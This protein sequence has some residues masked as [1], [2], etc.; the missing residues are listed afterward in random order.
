MSTSETAVRAELPVAAPVPAPEPEPAVPTDDGAAAYQQHR[1]QLAQNTAANELLGRVNQR[2]AAEAE[3]EITDEAV[4]R[5]QIPRTRTPAG[6]SRP[7]M[8]GRVAKDMALG[9]IEAPRAIVTGFRGA[10]QSVLDLEQE[11]ATFLETK[12]P[13][14]GIRVTNKDGE[15]EISYDE[16]KDTE[17]SGLEL[18]GINNPKSNTG[19]MLKSITQF[20]VGMAGASKIK[21]LQSLSSMGTA[22]A[23]TAA[24][25]KGA[26]ADFTVFGPDESRLSNL[27][28]Q[29]PALQNPV[30]EFLQTDP[31][32]NAAVSRFKNSLE[33]IPL[34]VLTDGFVAGIRALRNMRHARS[35][36]GFG[37]VSDVIEA[38]R[39]LPEDAFRGLGDDSV[40]PKGSLIR[41]RKTDVET[42]R[43]RQTG[44]KADETFINF[45]RI[46]SPDDVKRAMQEMADAGNPAADAAR[47]GR[48]TFAAV[49]LDA[50]HM[51]GWQALVNR[52]PGQPLGDAESLAARQLWVATT[53]KVT[54][55]AKTAAESPSEAN[56]FAF[57]KMLEVHDLVQSE[58]L[59]ARA[60]AA[61]SLASWRI[62]AGGPAERMRDVA[63][64]LEASGGKEVAQ[65]L[66]DRIGRLGQAGFY[67]EMGAVIQKTAYAKTRDAVIEG[68]VMGLLSGPKTHLVNM[69]SNTSVIGMNI[70][71]RGTA[72]QIA[73][74][75]GDEQ[76]VAL[77]EGTAQMFGII[78]GYKDAFR[79]AWKALKTGE[80]GFGLNK[81]ELPR[82]GS[83]SSQAF[84][85][86]NT[87]VGRAVDG[88]GNVVRTPGRMLG[89][90]DE[91]FKTIGYRME[92]NAQALRMAR[93]E[94]LAGKIAPDQFKARI[95]EIKA[96]PPENIRMAAVDQAMYQTFTNAT[97]P[98]A[99]NLSKIA[100]R[101]PLTRVLMPFIR[102]PA[103]IMKFTFERTPLAPLMS[104]VRADVAAG[105]AR[106]DLALAR[107]ATGTAIMLATTDHAMNGTIS[108]AG[109]SD[110]AE[111]A[112]LVRSG[113]QPYSVKAGER[114]YAYNRLDPMGALF[115]LSADMTEIMANADP[116][117]EEARDM[118]K[119]AVAMA[120]SIGANAMNKTYMTGISEFFEMMADP[121]R[122]SAYW[123]EGMAGSV[124]PTGV[125]E[126]RRLDDPYMR[127]VRSMVDA[128]KN[129]T[130]GLSEDLPKRRD[131][132]GRPM[133][134][135]SGVGAA[136][137][138]FSP[139]Y[140]RK[141]DPEPIDRE[142]I[143]GGAFSRSGDTEGAGAFN[144]P[145][146]S[147]NTSFDGTTVNLDFYPGAYSRYLE[148][149]GNGLKHP[150]WGVGA[151]D[152]LNQIVTGRHA[153]S[154]V[155]EIK[156]D[157]PDG[158]KET[159]IRDIVNQ[160]R[161][162]AR[163]QLLEEYP[164]LRME[165]EGKQ[166][167]KRELRMPTIQ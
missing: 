102:T 92:V 93:D 75:I 99:Q 151:K 28:Q 140:S 9:V 159:Y 156:S 84:G 15:F 147:R 24:A 130:P 118:E 47:A 12:L 131:L 98:F 82:E 6:E 161:E 55:L 19:M 83:I 22:G 70:Y 120:A 3:D 121:T 61:R 36:L 104:S 91:F 58:V 164:A 152:L 97:G 5:G 68:W 59:G 108:G 116:D 39:E 119:V 133:S 25:A 50:A 101:Y 80:T 17:V 129:R 18:P 136:Y 10:I 14:G 49:E 62:P 38:P 105:G 35:S 126:L 42:L 160:Y 27:I 163:R 135:E 46:D 34:G 117:S 96:N 53:D 146:P 72:A 44:A 106:R 142:I 150:A 89:A 40:G 67:P 77:G 123:A 107:I 31:A 66:A 11:L 109:P 138:M 155:Y 57:R 41:T 43:G 26:I 113:W 4:S 7:G 153:L 23:I 144:I 64:S 1:V 51:N 141:E 122:Y 124:V 8:T 71:E 127:E 2:Q 60:S 162:L 132:W 112:A 115:G 94:V 143:S 73:K 37:S 33:G 48:R 158:G 88:I 110:P 165:V 128:M 81:V 167:R 78:E 56:L 85:M 148:L 87:G 139:I 166:E 16:L 149:A 114:W 86:S 157:G 32:D 45:A 103:N 100:S 21:A 74:L 69:M 63:A 76:S 134:Y 54:E 111:R 90:E 137:D 125:S 13:L 145:M 79:F 154:Q 52:R 20:I 95:V 29:Y 65:E 30:T